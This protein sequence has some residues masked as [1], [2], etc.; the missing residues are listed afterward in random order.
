MLVSTSYDGTLKIWDVEKHEE[1][2]TLSGH[3]G[4][5][6][7]VAASLKRLPVE[8][9][10][11]VDQRDEPVNKCNDADSCKCNRLSVDIEGIQL[12]Q[13]ILQRDIKVNDCDL[14]N[15]NDIV[16]EFRSE[17]HDIQQRLD[18]HDNMNLTILAECRGGLG[19][20]QHCSNCTELNGIDN[21]TQTI[22]MET[23]EIECVKTNQHTTHCPDTLPDTINDQNLNNSVLIMHNT[24]PL[25]SEINYDNIM[26]IYQLHKELT[27]EAT[28]IDYINREQ[29]N[30]TLLIETLI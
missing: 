25:T 28:S 13:V 6:Y 3:Q 5:I 23:I 20:L 8:N 14:A 11:Q 24:T 29:H 16:S 12:E 10:T 18:K 19:L 15:L 1:I 22:E 9:S 17:F 4:N 2:R 26:E 7:S 30:L 27:P 21:S